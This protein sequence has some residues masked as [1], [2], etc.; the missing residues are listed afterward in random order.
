[1]E[2][3]EFC[4][5]SRKYI[6]FMIRPPHRCPYKEEQLLKCNDCAYYKLKEPSY[7]LKLKIKKIFGTVER[8]FSQC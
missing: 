6:T 4:T 1:M 8:L 7:Y 2:L 5:N 3:F